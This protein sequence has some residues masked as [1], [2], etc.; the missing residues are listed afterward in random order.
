MI[1]I[2]I[3]RLWP[4]T[5]GPMLIFITTKTYNVLSQ[6]VIS[7]NYRNKFGFPSIFP[8][9]QSD[10]LE[11]PEQTYS[12]FYYITF[13]EWPKCLENQESQFYMAPT[14]FQ[15]LL[16]WVDKLFKFPLT[17]V[18]FRVNELGF[19]DTWLQVSKLCSSDLGNKTDW[20]YKYWLMK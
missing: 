10:N 14:S 11:T 1:I 9:K 19:S 8:Y 15:L 18:S 13:T 16:Q 12:V 2:K 5:L 3:N 4:W 17:K 6:L 7:T 20:K